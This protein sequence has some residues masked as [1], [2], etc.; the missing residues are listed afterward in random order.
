MAHGTRQETKSSETRTRLRQATE[1][2]L[3]EVGYVGTSTVEVCRR[4]SLSRGALLHHYPTRHDLLVDTARHF[5][6]R[7]D[8]SMAELAQEL[9]RG[10]LDVRGFVEGVFREVFG[11]DRMAI[12]LELVVATRSD[13]ALHSA[14]AEIFGDLIASYQRSGALALSKCGLSPDQIRVVVTLVISTLR[15]LRMQEVAA[16]DRRAVDATLAS[17]IYAVEQVFAS[18]SAPFGRAIGVPRRTSRSAAGRSGDD[19]PRTSSRRRAPA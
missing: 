7:A 17:L 3:I 6:G 9:A 10:A 15:G 4:T 16:P 18:G 19:V 5:W 2:A 8:D 11:P 14:I 13:P 1:R 12:T